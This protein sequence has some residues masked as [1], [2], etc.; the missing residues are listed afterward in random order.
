[1]REVMRLQ[2]IAEGS[3]SNWEGRKGCVPRHGHRP[4]E[5]LAWSCVQFSSGSGRELQ[6]KKRDNRRR[7]VGT[8]GGEN[9]FLGGSDPTL[10]GMEAAQRL[11][12]R[13]SLPPKLS[14][15]L[16]RSVAGRAVSRQPD[17]IESHE[18]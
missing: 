7:R 8:D 2:G 9:R 1:M 12:R 10:S 16:P 15:R 17:K 14:I 18:P 3:R 4:V 11:R 6:E 13:G 5:F